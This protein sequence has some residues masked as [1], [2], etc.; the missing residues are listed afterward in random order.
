[1]S[2]DTVKKMSINLKKL[3]VKYAYSPSNIRDLNGSLAVFEGTKTFE[4]KKGT[5][6]LVIDFGI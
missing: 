6:R 2:Y 3:E 1:M 4:T 5:R